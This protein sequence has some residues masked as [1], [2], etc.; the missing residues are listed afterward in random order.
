MAYLLGKPDVSR[1]A[2]LKHLT[3]ITPK[4]G[5][6]YAKGNVILIVARA[7]TTA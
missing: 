3:D 6:S 2:A 7:A 4:L 5:Y 1:N